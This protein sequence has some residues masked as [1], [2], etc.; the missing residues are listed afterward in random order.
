MLGTL[1]SPNRP[2][3]GGRVVRGAARGAL[4][5]GAAAFNKLF[6]T[7]GRAMGSTGASSRQAD[8]INTSGEDISRSLFRQRALFK[9][10]L[11]NQI[12]Q[13]RLLE[14]LLVIY[15]NKQP[16][17]MMASPSAVPPPPPGIAMELP[18]PELPDLDRPSQR[19]QAQQQRPTPNRQRSF[20]RRYLTFIKRKSP[21]LYRAAARRI[22]VAAAGVAVPGPGWLMTVIAGLGSLMLAA[23]LYKMYREFRSS[24]SEDED[25]EVE[26][27]LPSEDEAAAAEREIDPAEVADPYGL[28]ERPATPPPPAPVATGRLAFIQF[29]SRI[30]GA[31]GTPEQQQAI[32]AAAAAM[33]IPANNVTGGALE[34]DRVTQITVRGRREPVMVPA[35]AQAQQQ[36]TPA[37]QITPATERPNREDLLAQIETARVEAERE[38]TPAAPVD[39]TLSN[40]ADNAESLAATSMIDDAIRQAENKNNAAAVLSNPPPTPP[41]VEQ[42]AAYPESYT[43]KDNAGQ[44]DSR[45]LD[46]TSASADADPVTSSINGI[47]VEGD[48]VIYDFDTI[49]YEADRIKFAGLTLAS[50]PA[51]DRA[52]PPPLAIPGV[53]SNVSA[54]STQSAATS[55]GRRAIQIMTPTLSALPLTTSS[56]P[57]AT[58][59]PLTPPAAASQPDATAATPPVTGTTAQILS[60]IR[61]R[62]SRGDYQAQSKTSTASGAYQFIDSTWRGVTRKFNIGTEYQRAVEAPPAVQDAVAA[63]YINDILR[64]NNNRVEVVPL[65]WYTGNAQG[66]MSDVAL[67]ANRGLTAETYQRDWMAT[68]A[69]QGGSVAQAQVAQAPSSGPAMAQASTSRVIADRQQAMS[70]QRVAQ[71]FNQQQPASTQQAKQDTPR[72]E[73]GEVPLRNRVL[74]AFNHLA[75]AS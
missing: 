36:E 2:S 19:P 48:T 67:A 4:K 13:N 32:R 3:I 40:A 73:T 38:E 28:L 33:N 6:P 58:A 42:P 1:P 16:I 63:A 44:D 70:S 68:F 55:G 9:N 11:E 37:Q 43:D 12:E 65:V 14:R 29:G 72:N 56:T 71:T 31:G 17:S 20:L 23:E 22:V 39:N 47:R 69:A 64:A 27:N 60:T 25:E 52:A 50:L 66:R 24:N 26:D 49:K 15:K 51:A 45:R 10:I 54:P 74:S 30:A 59:V 61:A 34:G 57:S 46:N 75:Q 8:S 18:M 62:E 35:P 41:P 7:I 5:L 53:A 21:R